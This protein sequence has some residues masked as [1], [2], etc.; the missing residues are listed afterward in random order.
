M[1]K[2]FFISEQYLKDNSSISLNVEPQLLNAA[3]MDAQTIHIQG[4]LGG[5]LYKKISDLIAD[6]SISLEANA[7]YK[8]LL[9]TYIAPTTVQYALAECLPYIRWK[10]MNKS[11]SSQQSDNTTPADLDEIKFLK[12]EFK[13]KAEF[14][15]QRLIEHLKYNYADYPEYKSPDCE[16]LKADDTAYFSG[17]QLDDEYDFARFLGLNTRITHL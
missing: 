9:D 4:L 5:T 6:G 16:D 7:V 13:N 12:S 17:I 14:Y 3:I 2:V 10:I 15:G 1:A 11:V 8:T